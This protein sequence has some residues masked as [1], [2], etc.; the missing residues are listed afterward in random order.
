[1]A[2]IC[3]LASYP[4][5]GN[6]WLR[7]FLANLFSGPEPAERPVAINDLSKF[8]IADDFYGDYARCAESTA[9]QLSEPELLRLR[10]RVHERFAAASAQTVFVKSHNAAIA[11][12][13]VPLI[14]P[15]ATTGAIYVA[16]NPL[17]IAVSYASHFQISLEQ[18]VAKLCDPSNSLPPSDGLM[19]RYLGSWSGH[20]RSW[21]RAPGLRL[22]LVRYEDMSATPLETFEGI[23]RYLGLP[24]ARARLERAM[25]FSSFAELERQETS[26]GFEEAR[27]DRKVR[28]FRQG[29]VGTWRQ[30]LSEAQ[31]QRLIE[32]HREVMLELGY[33]DRVGELKV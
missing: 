10:P 18:A 19:R 12:G 21:T 24:E 9:D 30:A 4:K 31:V 6:T 5:S 7:A 20:V 15:A 27:P 14:T 28:F 23:V 33:L 11:I 13:G 2:G 26:Q 1:M 22:H 32:A 17:D 8:C 25:A 29:Q 3:W 16:R